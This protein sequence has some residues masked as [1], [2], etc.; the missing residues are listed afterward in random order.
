MIE[1]NTEKVNTLHLIPFSSY[2]SVITTFNNV[3]TISCSTS[4]YIYKQIRIF[5]II[6]FDGLLRWKNSI[7]FIL[8]LY[9][10]R[11]KYIMVINL[12]K[13]EILLILLNGYIR[14]HYIDVS[15]FSNIHPL[16]DL[17]ILIFFSLLW[18]MMLLYVCNFFVVKKNPRK[19]I[20]IWI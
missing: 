1:M 20:A 19:V 15:F 18:A 14:F 17:Q 4:S 3:C 10:F 5:I 7:N 2:L 12:V 11:Q 16:T 9:F 13:W 8:Q 6:L